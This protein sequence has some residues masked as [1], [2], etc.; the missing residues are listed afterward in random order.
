MS[1]NTVVNP[2]RTATSKGKNNIVMQVNRTKE[3][4]TLYYLAD[5]GLLVIVTR[6]KKLH[7]IH[8]DTADF[9][10]KR[11]S[12]DTEKRKR[13]DDAHMIRLL[14]FFYK[15]IDQAADTLE[16]LAALEEILDK[17]EQDVPGKGK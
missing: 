7:Y 13:C 9:L 14:N 4:E 10:Y 8:G 16:T 2:I 11:L 5:A 1:Y 3:N 15:E 17:L 6:E 12:V